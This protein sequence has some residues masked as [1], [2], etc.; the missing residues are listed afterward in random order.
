[1]KCAVGDY[2]DG[3]DDQPS[4]GMHWFHGNG[5]NPFSSAN[6]IWFVVPSL[7]VLPILN[8]L[9]TDLR[10]REDVDRYLDG[11]ISGDNLS[12]MYDK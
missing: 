11:E 2:C 1:M 3:R 10:F 8:G 7:L 6:P 5:G 9:S 12:K 4:L